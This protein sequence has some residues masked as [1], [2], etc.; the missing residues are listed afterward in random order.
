MPSKGGTATRPQDSAQQ[1][2]Q[3]MCLCF[4]PL[5]SAT[6][7]T[8]VPNTRVVVVQGHVSCTPTKHTQLTSCLRAIHL[9][10]PVT[11]QGAS[12]P[13]RAMVPALS[14]TWDRR[15]CCCNGVLSLSPLSQQGVTTTHTCTGAHPNSALRPATHGT[16]DCWARPQPAGPAQDSQC[17]SNLWLDRTMWHWPSSHGPSSPAAQHR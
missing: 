3:P 5:T 2:L 16:C 9:C 7:G 12:G 15:L 1:Q 6:G 13:L 10:I 17:T 14:R 11:L 8:L 4:V